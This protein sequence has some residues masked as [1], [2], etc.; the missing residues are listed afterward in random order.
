MGDQ[1]SDN[2]RAGLPPVKKEKEIVCGIKEN[3][4]RV[5]CQHGRAAANGLLEVVGAAS[6]DTIQCASKIIG[7]CGS[8]PDWEV[9]GPQSTHKIGATES[10][11][12]RSV[13]SLPPVALVLPVWTGNISPQV[14]NV[15]VTACG[16]PSYTF[17]IHSYP[18]DSQSASID[19]HADQLSMEQLVDALKSIL[20][21]LVD[22]NKLEIEFLKGKGS[23]SLQWQE[24]DDSNLCR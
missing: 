18:L 10:F 6:G 14:Y 11:N 1:S 9:D 13:S 16:G 24:D 23:Y 20:G 12:A 5:T 4:V 8:H 17:E 21:L 15:S 2:M 3:S 7:T 19:L 22:E